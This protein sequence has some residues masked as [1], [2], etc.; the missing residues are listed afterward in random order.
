[1]LHYQLHRLLYRKR[2]EIVIELVRQLETEGHFPQANYAFDNGVLTIDL[3]RLIEQSG[4]HWV[5]E[6]EC[7]R[8]IHWGGRWRRVDEV[9]AAV[10]TQHPE[11]CRA[12]TVQCR[13]GT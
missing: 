10:R 11:S 6:I 2:T 13:N 7:S 5:S 4:K 3:T 9:V 8:H 1:M 12:V